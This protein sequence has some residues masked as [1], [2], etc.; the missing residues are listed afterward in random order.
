VRNAWN[1]VLKAIEKHTQTRNKERSD[2]V[3]G[4]VEIAT[5]RI[6]AQRVVKEPVSVLYPCHFIVQLYRPTSVV[7]MAA[8][9]IDMI[10]IIHSSKE[11]ILNKLLHLG[12]LTQ[13]WYIPA[14]T[15]DVVGIVAVE[16]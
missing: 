14:Y 1:T 6:T 11:S 8:I 5:P 12:F 2:G 9:T 10:R 3:C 16:I 4:I 7:E 13:T 15:K